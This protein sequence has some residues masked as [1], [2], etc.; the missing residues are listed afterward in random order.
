MPLNNL[1]SLFLTIY[2]PRNKI[3]SILNSLLKIHAQLTSIILKPAVSTAGLLNIHY[4]HLSSLQ[5][6]TSTHLMRLFCKDDRCESWVCWSLDWNLGFQ[7]DRC[8]S[9]VNFKHQILDS[10]IFIW[11]L[12]LYWGVPLNKF[13]VHPTSSLQPWVNILF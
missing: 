8:H 4:S 2:W 12:H 10:K 13:I 7:D 11:F 9:C 5:N 6:I 1:F 3:L